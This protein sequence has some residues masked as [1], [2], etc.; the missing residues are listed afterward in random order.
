MFSCLYRCQRRHSWCGQSTRQSIPGGANERRIKLKLNKPH[1][2][3][4]TTNT[5]ITE[6]SVCGNRIKQWWRSYQ[7]R[8][9]YKELN[10]PQIKLAERFVS[11]KQAAKHTEA[12]AWGR[13][14]TR[15][16]LWSLH[17]YTEYCYITT[18]NP[19]T[20]NYNSS[21]YDLMLSRRVSIMK[22]S[23]YNSSTLKI[24]YQHE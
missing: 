22:T 23:L 1:H 6:S 17:Y 3:S 20:L 11:V 15:T 5:P 24:W 14:K 8:L 16:K 12:N 21:I 13:W 9:V 10:V 18:R 19:F 2:I 7:I 4:E